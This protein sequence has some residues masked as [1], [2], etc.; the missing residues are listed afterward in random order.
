MA[1]FV[2]NGKEYDSVETMPPDVRET[3]LHVKD[4]FEDK[5]NNGVPDLM[6][7]DM[8]E[9]FADKNKD[10]IPDLLEKGARTVVTTRTRT[11][12]Q[13]DLSEEEARRIMSQ[14]MGGG[15]AFGSAGVHSSQP[16]P[17]AP[18]WDAPRTKRRLG[19]KQIVILLVLL[20]VL[21]VGGFLAWQ[22]WLK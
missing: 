5:N 18:Q 9:L 6:D 17:S 2:V 12:S 21:A 11:F 3:Y 20:D 13:R 14:A 19:I 16:M 22:F 10:G 1:K 4:M 8:D 15:D 7:M